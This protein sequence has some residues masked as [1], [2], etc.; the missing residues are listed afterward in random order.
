MSLCDNIEDKKLFLIIKQ[1]QK[2]MKEGKY[3][4]KIDEYAEF[5]AMFNMLSNSNIKDSI[6]SIIPMNII[7]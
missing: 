7:K 4:L 3:N 1:F 6:G 5:V 2:E